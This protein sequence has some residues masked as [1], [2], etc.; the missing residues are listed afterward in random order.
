MAD[1]DWQVHGDN[2]AEEAA[3]MG[4]QFEDARAL[5]LDCWEG[6]TSG[7]PAPQ[8][9]LYELLATWWAMAR[10]ENVPDSVADAVQEIAAQLQSE[11]QP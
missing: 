7:D 6:W 8:D 11:Q 5:M 9:L 2:L 1:A 10:M 3:R 4:G